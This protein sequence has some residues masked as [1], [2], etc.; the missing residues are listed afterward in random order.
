MILIPYWIQV[1]LI[2]ITLAPIN[3][4][5]ASTT[6]TWYAE[7][8]SKIPP[9]SEGEKLNFSTFFAR[10][11]SIQIHEIRPCCISATAFRR[12]CECTFRHLHTLFNNELSSKADDS[13][14]AQWYYAAIDIIE[15]KLYKPLIPMKRSLNWKS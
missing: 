14:F 12:Q 2:L 4:D 11:K 10:G 6:A 7:A 1:S 9:R 8:V 5:N 13:K 15:S 3:L